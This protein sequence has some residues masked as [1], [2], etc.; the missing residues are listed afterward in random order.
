MEAI[1]QNSRLIWSDSVKRNE[2]SSS[3]RS[4]SIR[5]EYCLRHV[6]SFDP[7]ARGG[8]GLAGQGWRT[9][10]WQVPW[11]RERRR[12]TSEQDRPKRIKRSSFNRPP[13]TRA[14]KLVSHQWKSCTFTGF[15]SDKK[16]GCWDKFDE[17]SSKRTGRTENPHRQERLQ[18]LLTWKLTYKN[19]AHR[20]VKQTC[21]C[22]RC[23]QQGWI[24]VIQDQ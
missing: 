6:T 16:M 24:I 3:G 20:L 21:T 11:K 5:R 15:L 13:P 17:T 23:T 12:A 10:D 19:I 1:R 9:S 18:I 14:Q 7:D 2:G 8:S 22:I 4:R